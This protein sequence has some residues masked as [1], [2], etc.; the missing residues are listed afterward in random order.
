MGRAARV[1]KQVVVEAPLPNV[2]VEDREEPVLDVGQALH[3]ELRLV[4]H[5][6]S[7]LSRGS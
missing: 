3:P 7:R 6:P 4:R 1:A 5:G 2:E